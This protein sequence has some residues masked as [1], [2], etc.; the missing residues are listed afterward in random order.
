MLLSRSMAQRMQTLCLSTSCK[1]IKLGASPKSIRRT[2]A[3][4]ASGSVNDYDCRIV[5]AFPDLDCVF[6]NSGIQRGVDFSKP[7]TVDLDLMQT[8]FNVNY[9][10]CLALTKAFLPF[11]MGKKEE[12]GIIL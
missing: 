1:P 11:L 6:L 9:F 12:T 4:R 10:S 5:K 3:M 7:E 2:G 8:E